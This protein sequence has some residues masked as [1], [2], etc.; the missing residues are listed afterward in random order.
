MFKKIKT[1]IVFGVLLCL[2]ACN[3]ENSN[4][5]LELSGEWKVQLDPNNVGI[6]ENWF[7]KE[8]KNTIHLPG[9]TDEA[10]L[11]FPEEYEDPYNA[12]VRPYYY[13]GKA[14]YKREIE[15]PEE[16]NN[17]QFILF[18]ERCHWVTQVWVNE[19]Y[20]G[21]QNSL[22]AAH[23]YNLTAFLRPGKHMLTI[24]V[25]NKYPFSL[26]MFASSVSEHTQS[27]WNGIV[28]RIEL[29]A[30]D[31]VYMDDLRVYPD[32]NNKQVK[33]SCKVF[34]YTDEV[35]K[36]K[37]NIEVEL[38]KNGKKAGE[39][40]V[41][42][43]VDGDM[44][45]IEGIVSM[46][47]D[48][49][50]WDEFS[51]ELYRLK[52]NLSSGKY[53]NSKISTFGMRELG[54]E[55]TIFT[56]N[57]KRTYL[58]GNLECCIF[59]ETGYPPMTVDG[60]M[61]VLKTMKDYGLNHMRTHSWCPP[62]AAFEAADILGMY[63]QAEAP[64]ANV[65]SNPI[66]DKFI[67]EE[68][69]RINEAYGNNP[70]FMF[71]TS[72]N[73]LNQHGPDDGVNPGM[74]A[75]AKNDD[76][77]HLYST[78]SGGH[79]MDHKESRTKVDEYR[80]GGQRGFQTPGTNED[81]SNY[82]RNYEFASITHEVG[83]HAMY[84]NL[85]EIP[86]Y[87]GV[88]KPVNL[89][90][91]KNDLKEKGMLDKASL[92]TDATAKHAAI[93]Y[94]EEIEILMRSEGNGGFQLLSL[95]D[96]PGQGTAHVGL[97]DAFWENKG[98]I[99]KDEFRKF[100]SPV[101]PLLRMHKRT[102]F[103]NEAFWARAEILNYGQA[104]INQ[105]NAIW[106]IH[107]E[108]GEILK[109]GAFDVRII[110]QGERVD[111]G[112]ISVDLSFVKSAKKLT[113]SVEIEGGSC[114]NDWDIWCY[115]VSEQ[116]SWPKDL[117]ISKTADKNVIEALE[118]GKNV[119]LLPAKENLRNSF[120]GNP[121]TVFW[122][123]TWFWTKPRGGNTTMS[124]LCDIGHPVFED[125]PTEYHSN[126]Q[127]WSL[128][129]MSNSIILDSLTK[130]VQ[131]II[132]VIDNFSRNHQLGTLIEAKVGNGKLMICSMDIETKLTSRPEAIQLRNSIIKY[133]K[134]DEFEPKQEISSSE[135]IALFR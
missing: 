33:I 13:A 79:G 43:D 69:L 51:P 72:G 10:G 94:K 80:V 104:A 132:R 90:A 117:I 14:W 12:L 74:I 4:S 107:D 16:W 27:N 78:T 86:K 131:P 87:T 76:N 39:Q 8:L 118:S 129:E 124:I 101:T 92:F 85:L 24:C 70:S 50:L 17:K 64:R 133:M 23:K 108:D 111:L 54:V 68:L 32:I 45:I 121:K 60:W 56:V 25:D 91:I 71:V 22:C 77:R 110:P 6:K 20:V 82:Y 135:L 119:L 42:F 81:L 109:K 66:R 125:F 126:W 28:G 113:V 40:T 116:N 46:G 99:T 29:Q 2:L 41:N 130:N 114:Y 47:D 5:V 128:Q 19:Q 18:L 105:A 63:I 98:G 123:P 100:C 1:N 34:N 95:Q 57:N 21:T 96:Y 65:D 48:V 9:T 83:Q 36:G 73:E 93:L 127:W 84:P 3:T 134:S 11:G 37:L 112:E 62:K 120:A 30:K 59:P 44:A 53:R 15:I 38:K 103:N 115:P 106:K 35:V 49:Q 7:D 58:R 88:L 61:K 89:E 102:F 26:G 75:K 55:G 52:A 97:F 31:L 67:M 122:S